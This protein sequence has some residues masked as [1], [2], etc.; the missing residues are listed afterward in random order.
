MFSLQNVWDKNVSILSLLFKLS[1]KFGD[2][3]SPLF[4]TPS[5]GKE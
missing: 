3:A 4:N 2:G 1:Y 5:K